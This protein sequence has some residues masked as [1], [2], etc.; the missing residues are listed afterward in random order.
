M[1]ILGAYGAAGEPQTG[2]SWEGGVAAGGGAGT[3]TD[4]FTGT[5]AVNVSAID[6]ANLRGKVQK[7]MP[8]WNAVSNSW[9][10][11]LIALGIAAVGGLAYWGY[12]KYGGK[13]FGGK[14]SP[15]R[16]GRKR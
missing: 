11:L 6:S 7:L 5:A 2:A 3:T 10:P 8:G 16:R 12:R 13:I 15:K 9:K 14:K 4:P 1:N